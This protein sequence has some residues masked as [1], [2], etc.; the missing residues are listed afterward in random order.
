M[1]KNNKS[2]LTFILGAAIG[3]ALTYLFT[4]QKGKAILSDAK[5]KSRDMKNTMKNEMVK[6]RF[7][8]ETLKNWLNRNASNT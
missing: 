7:L 5:E 1:S 6:G 8:F 3:S 4:S 2:L